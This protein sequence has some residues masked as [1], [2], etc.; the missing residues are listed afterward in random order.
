MVECYFCWFFN[1][2]HVLGV[3]CNGS[4]TDFDSVCPCSNQGIPSK[5]ERTDSQELIVG[6]YR[7]PSVLPFGNAPLAQSGLE[8]SAT[9]VRVGGSNPSGCAISPWCNGSIR[10]SKTL[11]RGS[12]PCGDAKQKHTAYCFGR[13]VYRGTVC[14][15]LTTNGVS[16]G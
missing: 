13:H 16:N 15:C 14:F 6:L 3:W 7:T 12:S 1:N 8:H 11:G 2:L 5:R 4:T 9:N 10:V